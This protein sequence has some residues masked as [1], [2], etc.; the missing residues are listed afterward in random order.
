MEGSLTYSIAGFEKI[1][2]QG[3][4]WAVHNPPHLV[5]FV[6]LHRPPRAPVHRQS[7]RQASRRRCRP[8]TVQGCLTVARIWTRAK[9]TSTPLHDSIYYNSQAHSF[10]STVSIY[11][12]N[13]LDRTARGGAPCSASSVEWSDRS[14]GS[15]R[16]VAVQ[17]GDD[18][19]NASPGGTRRGKRV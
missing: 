16:P 10:H 2:V 17:N 9:W 15:V 14:E 7:A 13:V 5:S 19:T 8:S 3:D 18:P 11:Y 4:F 1:G 12:L 6:R